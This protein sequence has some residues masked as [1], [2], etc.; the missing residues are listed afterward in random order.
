MGVV[1]IQAFVSP[2]GQYLLVANQ[3]TEEYPG[4]TVLIIDTKTFDFVRTVET[5]VGAHG[6]TID[7]TSRHAYITNTF[8]DTVSVLD[9]KTL[10]VVDLA[11]GVDDCT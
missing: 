9:L 4:R 11:M 1:P 3:G 6:V 5:G 7:P 2:A 8:D 10:K